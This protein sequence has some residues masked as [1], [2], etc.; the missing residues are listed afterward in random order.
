MI[1][2]LLAK[3][4]P[5]NANSNKKLIAIMVNWIC[6]DQYPGI[7]CHNCTDLLIYFKRTYEVTVLML[8]LYA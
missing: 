2:L 6:R 8:K 3:F 1:S 5:D 7:C 4:A